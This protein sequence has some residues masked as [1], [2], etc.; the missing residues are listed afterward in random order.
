MT[1]YADLLKDPRW[2]KR[3]LEVM[4]RDEFTCQM[5]GAKD[6]TLHVHHEEYTCSNPWDE[7]GENLRT[8]CDVCHEL[9]RER[10]GEEQDLL[11]SLPKLQPPSFQ[12]LHLKQEPVPLPLYP[13]H[14]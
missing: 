4:Q 2:Q 12:H 11:H 13:Q 6:K 9:E 3:R 10:K 8:L 1:T 7:P 5:C 14:Q